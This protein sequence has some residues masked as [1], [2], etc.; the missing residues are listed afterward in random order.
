MPAMSRNRERTPSQATSSFVEITSPELSVTLVR[1]I[2]VSNDATPFS[3]KRMTPSA[4]PFLRSAFTSSRFSTICAKGSSSCASF[5]KVRNTGRV[6]SLTLLSVTIISLIG[7]AFL[8]R[9]CQRPSASNMREASA[10]IAE[11][12]SSFS[13]ACSGTGSTTITD[14]CGAASL[15]ATA[16]D[17]PTYPPPAMSTSTLSGN[18]SFAVLAISKFHAFY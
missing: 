4:S 1:E 6:T 10:A 13:T 16:Q 5:A 18:F 15:I 9:P 11:A 7:C 8:I 2:S 17:K 3:V 12:R 14:K